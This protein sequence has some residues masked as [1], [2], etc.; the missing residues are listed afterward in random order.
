MLVGILLWVLIKPGIKSRYLSVTYKVLHVGINS[1]S[2]M[3]SRYH[4][5]RSLLSKPSNH[6]SETFPDTALLF[7]FASEAGNQ[8]ICP[9]STVGTDIQQELQ[10]VHEKVRTWEEKKSHRPKQN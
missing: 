2:K 8:V 9:P 5:L 7:I 6:F 3:S 10:I 4:Q 1:E